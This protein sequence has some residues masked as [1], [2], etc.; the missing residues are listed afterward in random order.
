MTLKTLRRMLFGAS[1]IRIEHPVFGKALLIRT[2]AG[3][4]W[5]GEAIVEKKAVSVSVE[6][7][8]SEPPS[9]QQAEFFQR[10]ARTSDDVFEFARPLL[11]KE[12]ET[13]MREPFPSNWRDAFEFVGL[14]VPIDGDERQPWDISF[15]CVTDHRGHMF[16]CYVEEG[17]PS[18]VTIDG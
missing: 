16:T 18:Y 7:K 4:Y 8:A 15:D 6:T 1:P 17:R 10:I 3:A 11:V 13:W 14:T 9:M 5:E 12:Y 2:K